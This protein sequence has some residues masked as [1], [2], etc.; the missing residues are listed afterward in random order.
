LLLG[1][2]I[3]TDSRTSCHAPKIAHKLQ[4]NLL[5]HRRWQLLNWRN[6]SYVFVLMDGRMC[7]GC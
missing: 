7:G 3:W 2:N 1:W 4:F 5:F 6:C